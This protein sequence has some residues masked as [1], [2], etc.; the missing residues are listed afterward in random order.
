M[1]DS[2]GSSGKEISAPPTASPNAKEMEAA[3]EI[4]K[5][6]WDG[7][8]DLMTLEVLKQS[9]AAA[10]AEVRIEERQQN[11]K[12]INDTLNE[13]VTERVRAERA[14]AEVSRMQYLYG[15]CFVDARELMAPDTFALFVDAQDNRR[16]IE[17]PTG[18]KGEVEFQ[19]ARAE[20]AEAHAEKSEAS[21][22][23]WRRQ[24]TDDRDLRAC[25]IERMEKAEAQLARVRDET[26][27]EAARCAWYKKRAI[28]ACEHVP[29]DVKALAAKTVCDEIENSI[30]ALKLSANAESGDAAGGEKS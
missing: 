2:Q 21:R 18:A 29:G 23:A 9:I 17:Y 20:Q 24:A 19:T 14:E 15:A 13:L 10:L 27:E 6:H 8:C 4:A 28:E 7:D 12:A 11:L 22:D 30:R 16:S 5:A 25:A 1:D 26:L 3:R